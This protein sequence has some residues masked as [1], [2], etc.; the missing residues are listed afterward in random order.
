MIR[1]P[2]RSTLFPYTTLF[3]SRLAAVIAPRD[4]EQV[5]ARPPRGHERTVGP[6]GHPERHRLDQHHQ[7]GQA[8][9]RHHRADGALSLP[10]CELPAHR[11]PSH[12]TPPAP[13]PLPPPP[14]P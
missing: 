5:L 3:R 4:V 1:R 10:H 9:Q 2:P 14:P 6:V 11:S 12:P 13:P 7:H 8:Q